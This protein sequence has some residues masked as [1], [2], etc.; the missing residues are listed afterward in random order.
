MSKKFSSVQA[1]V[2]AIRRGEVV[3]VM[4]AEDRENEGDYICAAELVTAEKI[5]F[6][7]CGR[8]QLCCPI[9]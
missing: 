5:N 6:M 1:A 9:L 2:D 8:G 7:L 4:D 3:I